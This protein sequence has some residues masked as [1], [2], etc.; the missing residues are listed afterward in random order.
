M[1]T[2][3]ILDFTATLVLRLYAIVIEHSRFGCE[4]L[5]RMKL[6]MVLGIINPLKVFT[7][8]SHTLKVL[9]CAQ[10]HHSSLQLLNGF[11]CCRW[12]CGDVQNNKIEGWK[13]ELRRSVIFHACVFRQRTDSCKN[14]QKNINVSRTF[15]SA[16]F[17]VT[18]GLRII[19]RMSRFL[20][21]L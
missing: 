14:L 19:F 3:A 7:H 20:S 13:C 15:I 2:A 6:P 9:P 8:H 11:R 12:S 1:A 4:F 17:R 5:T 21:K 16:Q 10:T 18:M